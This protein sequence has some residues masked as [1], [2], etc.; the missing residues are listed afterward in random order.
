MIARRTVLASAAAFV[1]AREATAQ[2]WPGRAVKII[3]VTR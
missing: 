1:V 3:V 2:Q